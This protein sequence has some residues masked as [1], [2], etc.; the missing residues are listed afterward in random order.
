M[1][2]PTLLVGALLLLWTGWQPVA[3]AQLNLASDSVQVQL[4]VS[5]K[6]RTIV[7]YGTVPLTLYAGDRINPIGELAPEEKLTI[8]TG[9]GQLY[10]RQA[11]AGVFA[12]SI[13]VAQTGEGVFG[14]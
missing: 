9:N 13:Y 10:L 4:F 1:R 11:D 5:E 3:V 12:R 14:L 2:R 6:P 8:T 7:L